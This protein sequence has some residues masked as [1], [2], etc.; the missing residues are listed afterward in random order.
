MTVES[1]Q[2]WTF[3]NKTHQ[4]ITKVDYAL[5]PAFAEGMFNSCKDVQMP[6]SNNKAISTLC[7]EKASACT[8]AKLLKYFGSTAE[9]PETPFDIDFVVCFSEY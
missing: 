7:N 8:P 3:D 2:S 4:E 6:T 5:T 1:K 9:N